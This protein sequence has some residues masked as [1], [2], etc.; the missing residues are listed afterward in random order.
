MIEEE[1][2][3][4]FEDKMIKLRPQSKTQIAESNRQLVDQEMIDMPKLGRKSTKMVEEV[5]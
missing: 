2:M 5:E 3:K 1:R 4:K